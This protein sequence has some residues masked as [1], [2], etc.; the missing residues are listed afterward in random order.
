MVTFLILVCI[1]LLAGL[2][3]GFVGIG[4]GIV[5]VPTLIFF[6][7][8]S[9]QEAQGTSLALMLPPIGVLAAYNY[10]KNGNLNIK[11]AIIVASAFVVG[12]FF[13][14][15]IALSL[16]ADVVREIFAAI[17]FLIS[18]KYIFSKK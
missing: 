13:G 3:S 17:V 9:Q 12:G 5:I 1:G 14:S 8:F 2:L 11:Y 7:G 6:M 16:K 18:L 10:Y 4:G 15:K